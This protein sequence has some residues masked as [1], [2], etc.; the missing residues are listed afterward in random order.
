MTMMML[1]DILRYCK[2]ECHCYSN[3]DS[4]VYVDDDDDDDDVDDDDDDD[5]YNHHQYPHQVSQV[6][7]GATS[8]PP[9]GCLQY[10]T[11]ATGTVIFTMIL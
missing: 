11:G 3:D 9:L 4:D 10:H 6:E 8:L 5:D 2:V 7:C 1:I